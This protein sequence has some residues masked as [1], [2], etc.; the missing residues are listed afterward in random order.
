MPALLAITVWIVQLVQIIR[1]I[2]PPTRTGVQWKSRLAC[3]NCIFGNL[4][5]EIIVEG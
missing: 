3:W 4:I 1:A 2:V 5:T